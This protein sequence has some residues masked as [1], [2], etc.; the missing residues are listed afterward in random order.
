MNRLIG[1]RKKGRS[2]AMH[3]TRYRPKRVFAAARPATDG[4]HSSAP[5]SP[6][7]DENFFVLCTLF[8]DTVADRVCE[9]RRAELNNKGDFS[10]EG[11]IVD[12]VLTI[13]QEAAWAGL[14]S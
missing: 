11:C 7:S 5:S 3:K 6:A 1:T 2:I 8:G 10:C 9:L 4:M 13:E 14:E 12:M